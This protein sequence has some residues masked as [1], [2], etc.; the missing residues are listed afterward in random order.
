MT[1]PSLNLSFEKHSQSSTTL[2]SQNDNSARNSVVVNIIPSPP[3]NSRPCT[4][5]KQSTKARSASPGSLKNPLARRATTVNNKEEEPEIVFEEWDDDSTS[6][7]VPKQ[8]APDPYKSPT[9]E[10]TEVEFKD[11]LIS[12]TCDLLLHD[13]DLLKNIVERGNKV[14]FHARQLKQLIAILYLKKEDRRRWDELVE[15]ETEKIVVSNCFCKD[16]YNPLYLQIKNIFVLN[17]VNFMS[18]QHS[19]V[20]N[21]I[22]KISLELCLTGE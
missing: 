10:D 11:Q 6:D 3:T 19:V 22:F 4:P 9:F 13:V 14:I 12:F 7:E 17:K 18:T 20:M 2:S 5:K 16:C 1:L 15:I 8:S 21:V